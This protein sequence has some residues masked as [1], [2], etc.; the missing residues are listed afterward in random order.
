MTTQAQKLPDVRVEQSAVNEENLF[1]EANRERLMGN[2]DDA[3]SKLNQL[4]KEYGNKAVFHYEMGRVYQEIGEMQKALEEIKTAIELESDNEWY[5]QYQANLA[6][7]MELEEDVIAAY[8]A[9]SQLF[10]KKHYYLENI[11]FHQ[12]RNNDPL[13]ALKT[14]TAL[15]KKAG[16]N[17]ETTRQK[18]LIFDEMGDIKAATSEL[19]A[20]IQNYPQDQR[21]ILIAA[22]YSYNNGD[23]KKAIGYYE[24][25]L[26]LD[27]DNSQAKSAL[28]KLNS[29][30]VEHGHELTSFINNSEN[31]LDDKILLLI[32]A[33]SD[34]QTGTSTIPI[35][36]IETYANTIIEQHGESDKTLALLG[37]I[38]SLQ[39]KLTES[40]T[41][42]MKSIKFNDGN[43]MVWEQLL[44][45]LTD[46]DDQKRLKTYA[47]EAMDIYPNKSLP[48]AFY[49]YSVALEN[50][51]DT[52]NSL[53]K[54]ARI[55]S[56][57]NARLAI[58]ID[59]LALRIEKLKGQ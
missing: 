11:A 20:Y 36:Q 57:K 5:W 48:Y 26:E 28:L 53:I 1:I 7:E 55:I 27:P 14:L 18:H 34:F 45:V 47:E 21:M 40:V 15:E 31:S 46:M 17:F 4:L 25:L 49:A 19:E 23:N 33:L 56:G 2:Y 22:S 3:E 35:E 8:S 6:E 12:L 43:Y 50:D 52:A 13:G 38:Y 37:D 41:Q 51:F 10:P 39:N 54:R 59:R 29:N 9:L 32:P 42:Y 30:N 44:Y 16:R 58:E 24:K